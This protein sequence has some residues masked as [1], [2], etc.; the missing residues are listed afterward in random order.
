MKPSRD[1]KS[2]QAELMK[3][4]KYKERNLWICVDSIIFS[5]ILS[6]LDAFARD[7]YKNVGFFTLFSKVVGPFTKFDWSDLDV[8]RRRKI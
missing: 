3:H 7:C 4:N 1:I 6:K 5:L 2:V 8:L